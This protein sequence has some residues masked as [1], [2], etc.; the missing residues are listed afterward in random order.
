MRAD[1]DRHILMRMRNIFAFVML[2]MSLMLSAGT[3]NAMGMAD[4][5]MAASSAGM[6]HDKMDCCKP[7]C[8]ANCATLCPNLVVP[9]IFRSEPPRQSVGVKLLGLSQV[10]LLSADQSGTDP[11]PRTII[12]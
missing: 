12:S 4:C 5:P 8:A 11:P 10:P 7:A 9:T 2:A 3:A 1:A 6:S